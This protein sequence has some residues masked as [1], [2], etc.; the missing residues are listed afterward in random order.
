MNK[1]SRSDKKAYYKATV[2]QF[3][4]I[5]LEQT[6]FPKKPLRKTHLRSQYFTELFGLTSAMTSPKANDVFELYLIKRP[7]IDPVIAIFGK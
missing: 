5:L 1:M 2:K 4:D 7:L 6:T 3:A